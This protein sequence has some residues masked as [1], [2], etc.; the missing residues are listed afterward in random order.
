MPA[1]PRPREGID[2]SHLAFVAVLIV[3]GIFV[4]LPVGLTFV[5]SFIA[6]EI[7]QPRY[8]SL[9]P[10]R[11]AFV[12]PGM[13]VALL[14]TAKV[15]LANEVFSMPIAI[16]FAWLLG[17]TDLPGRSQLEF[18]FWISFFLP[19]LSVTLGWIV[20]LD[21]QNGLINKLVMLLPFVREPPFDIYSF[22]G[23]VWA[24]LG[25]SAISVKVMLLTPAFRNLDGSFEE[26]ARMSGAGRWQTLR[27][28]VLPLAMPAIATVLALSTIRAMQT[29]EIEMV[30]GP[31][32]NFWVFGTLIYRHIEQMPPRFSAATALSVMSFAVILP[33][34]FAHRWILSRKDYTSVSGRMRTSPTPLGLLRWPAFILVA[35]TALAVTALPVS[36]L[37]TSS[38]MKLFGFFEIADP[39]TRSNW[40]RVLADS[41]FDRALL[42]TLKIAAGTGVCAMLLCSL[43]AW[44]V[45][46][47]RFRGRS[48]LDF[49]SWLPFA[50]PGIL[51]GVGILSVVLATPILKPL[52]GTLVL[53]IIATTVAH[54]TMGSQILKAAL[55]QIDAALEEAA[56]MSGAKW[57]TTFRRI[58]APILAPTLVLVGV[59][60]FIGATRDISS[61]A[62]LATNETKPLSLLQL[63]YMMDGRSESAAVISVVVIILTTGI[64]LIC[65]MLGLRVGTR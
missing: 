26:A 24:H 51:L 65:R 15:V 32:S 9:D 14:N 13:R 12:D 33:L 7:G 64:A 37:V 49:L 41:F 60:S 42:S 29:F 46:R 2:A 10:W 57:W 63:D 54:M 35:G 62:L 21:P 22:W 59:T 45:V 56:R 58:V 53:L 18:L 34:I 8:W 28:I 11:E 3:I 5:N 19:S 1:T 39:W 43:I 6:G 31:P 20:L 4:L 38:F 27:R 44:F 50:I 36:M 52:Y 17:R 48:V 47:S 55:L 23:I 30:L 40:T 61:V 25:T 16:L